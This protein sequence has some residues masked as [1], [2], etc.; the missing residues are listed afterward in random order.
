MASKYEQLSSYLREADES[1]LLLSF[2]DVD[3]IVGGLPASARGHRTWWG[4]SSRHP[5]AVAWISAGWIVKSVDLNTQQ[6]VLRR[7]SPDARGATGRKQ[8]LDGTAALESVI[9]TAGYDSIEAALAE[10]TI[11]LH[12]DTVGQTDGQ[13]VVPVVRDPGRRGQFGTSPDGSRVMFC[14]NQSATNVFLWAADRTKG[15]DVQF[16]PCVEHRR[17]PPFVHRALECVLHAGLSRQDN[18]QSSGDYVATHIP[19]VRS[20]RM[21]PGGRG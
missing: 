6:V 3:A 19:L 10:H 18:R 17:G 9:R 7:G 21:S 12:P 8:I 14:D 11:F 13:A 20:L 2:A 4:N 15:P 1:V 16:Q 5:H